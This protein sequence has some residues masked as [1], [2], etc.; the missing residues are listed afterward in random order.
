M[1]VILFLILIPSL[2]ILLNYI[3]YK[4]SRWEIFI[5]DFESVKRPELK[6]IY[7]S[8]SEFRQ[9]S[10]SYPLGNNFLKLAVSPFGL[11]L[12]YDLKYEPIKFYKPVMIPWDNILVTQTEESVT[13]GFDEYQ[14][15]KKGQIAGS[16]FLQFPISSQIKEESKNLGIKLNFV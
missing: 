9:S 15:I 5:K 13:K 11:Y 12:Q 7:G 4:L 3:R 1:K 10:T 6:A 2:V 16:L 14:I 8:W